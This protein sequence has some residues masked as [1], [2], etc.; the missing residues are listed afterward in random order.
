[1]I[2]SLALGFFPGALAG[3]LLTGLLFFLNPHI[4]FQSASI[5]RGILYYGFLLGSLSF[6][7]YLGL[8]IRQPLPPGTWLPSS[9]TLVLASFSLAA[10][11]HA[12]YFVFFLPWGIHRRLLKAAIWLTLAALV[13]FYTT[14]IHRLRQ[15]PFGQRSLLLILAMAAISIYVVLERRVAF[16]PTVRPAP[17]A[18]TFEGTARP[19]LGVVGLDSA[20]FDA[21]LPLEEQGRLPFFSQILQE[22]AHTRLRSL[23][24]VRKAALWTT[25]STGRLP[26]RHGVFGPQ[27]YRAKPL[28]EEEFFKLLPLAV[29]F[30]RWG[31]LSDPQLTDSNISRN[32]SLWDIFSR[33]GI[34]TG[35]VGWPL[36]SPPPAGVHT[37]LPDR[38]FAT[39]GISGLVVPE[40]LG[41]RARL[42]RT[43]IEEIDPVF[44]DRFGPRPP[45]AVL[46]S[47]AQD[48]WR[49]DLSSV[50]L[51]QDPQINAFFLMLPGLGQVSSQYFGGFSAVQFEGIQAPGAEEAS[52]Q[53]SAYY[54][55]IDEILAEIWAAM[56]EPRLL[57]LVSVHG[58]EGPRGW[59]EL[60][61]RLLRQTA[62]E[63]YIDGAPDG[64]LLFLGDGIRA[65]AMPKP[66]HLV[67]LVP[68]LLYGM[69]LPIARD[70][71]GNVLTDAFEPAFLA[72]QALTLVPSYETLS[73][74][75]S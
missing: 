64:V 25:L 62:V 35:L 71:D 15:R 41:E 17:R 6:L 32:L 22:G 53:L 55:Q 37:V 44:S 34:P 2:R 74:P 63:G 43:R 9:V 39:E 66:A 12:L 3:A 68:T 61:R 18:T 40:D 50:L 28:A 42:F 57:V 65:G 48:L 7:I 24:P 59:R 75:D 10:W 47:L 51:D 52:Q 20:T 49:R 70:L 23:R 56:P 27:L 38:F 46:E 45:R 69:G 14:L 67:D 13:C 5:L 11:V 30:E 29:G 8:K 21:I 36:T 19:F 72:R 26:N 31:V 1:M 33:I 16:R 4:P 58:V 54:T 60:R 73:D